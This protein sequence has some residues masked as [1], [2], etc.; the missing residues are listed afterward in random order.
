VP[1]V[2]G[3]ELDGHDHSLVGDEGLAGYTRARV[4]SQE[5]VED[6]VR[7]AVAGLVRR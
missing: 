1:R 7:T 5:G 6:G 2:G 3:A 4:E